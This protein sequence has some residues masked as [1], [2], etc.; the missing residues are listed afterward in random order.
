MIRL[1]SALVLVTFATTLLVVLRT[2]G[3]TATTLM[4][5]GAPSLVLGLG[6]W[7]AALHRAVKSSD[8]EKPL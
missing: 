5:V 2:N 3:L 1:A 7:G 6:L 8:A 4:F